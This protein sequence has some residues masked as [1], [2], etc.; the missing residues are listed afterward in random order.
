MSESEIEHLEKDIASTEKAIIEAKE[1]PDFLKLKKEDKEHLLK[2]L[3]AQI[4][5][6]KEEVKR[7]IKETLSK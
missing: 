4:D 1:N 2:M 6:L 7:R 3:Q 5:F